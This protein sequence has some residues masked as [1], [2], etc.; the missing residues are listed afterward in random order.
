MNF[1]LGLRAG[2]R[3]LHHWRA[4]GDSGWLF[5]SPVGGGGGILW[6]PQLHSVF[7]PAWL[8]GAGCERVVVVFDCLQCRN[9]MFSSI[10]SAHLLLYNFLN[11]F[12]T[13]Y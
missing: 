1:K 13:F 7:V 2:V 8:N 4:R 11:I 3:W 5:K 6:R 12:L 9:T 10:N